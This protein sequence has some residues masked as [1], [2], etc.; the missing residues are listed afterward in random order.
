MH[1]PMI[2]IF[3]MYLLGILGGWYLC[4][5]IPFFGLI[6]LFTYYLYKKYRWNGILIFPIITLLGYINIGESTKPKDIALDLLINNNTNHSVE[7]IGNVYDIDY[8]NDQISCVI[9]SK[10][11]IYLNEVFTIPLKLK[12]YFKNPVSIKW[13]DLLHI[14]GNIEKFNYPR[15]PGGFNEKLYMKTRGIEYK[16]FSELIDKKS[17]TKNIKYGIYLLKFKFNKIYDSILPLKQSALLKAMLLGEK[18]TLDEEQKTM[19]QKAG[20][21]HILAI[22]GLHISILSLFLWKIFNYI[23]IPDK[24]STIFILIFL[25]SYYIFTGLN[26]STLRAVL[27]VSIALIGNLIRRNY[28]VYTSVTMAAFLILIKQPLYLWDAGFQLSFVAVLGLILI[29]PCFEKIYWIPKILRKILAPIMGAGLATLPIVSYHFYYISIVGFIL[30]LFIVPLASLVV[31]FGF[32]GGVLGFFWETGA[33]FTIGIVHYILIFYEFISKLFIQIPYSNIIIGRPNILFIISYYITSLG[34]VFYIFYK[35]RH[36]LNKKIKYVFLFLC[37]LLLGSAL[38][39]PNDFE[40]VFLDVGQGDSI[41]IHTNKNKTLLID[42]GEKDSKKVLLPYF[43]YKGISQIDAIFL[44]HPDRDHLIGLLGLLDTM[45]IKNI[46]VSVK[47]NGKDEIYHEF[48]LKLKKLQIPC[49]LLKQGDK[50]SIDDISIYC[51]YP[52]F[53]NNKI[54]EKESWNEISMVLQIIYKN[55][56]FLL[57]GDIEKEQENSIINTYQ[58]I[59]C[60][61]LKVPHHGSNT[62]S[63][64]KFL[65]WSNPK[66][67]IISC[68]RNNR[69]GHP[70]Q[71]VLKRYKEYNIPVII[72]ANSGAIIIKS[73]GENYKIN[74]M[75]EGNKDEYKRIKRTNKEK[76]I[77]TCLLIIW[78]GIFFKKILFRRN[79]K[80]VNF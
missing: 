75:I 19:Y 31:G 76:Y 80:K 1:R 6:M 18:S 38:F 37:T 67:A 24:I 29:D 2:W 55:N 39:K 23:R 32:I 36:K 27:M 13:G 15:N 68:G 79:T 3:L 9:E 5:T 34:I 57:T 73:N 28:D 58:P 78:G 51:L 65:D 40:M 46:F 72:T 33:Y 10:K 53:D 30:N 35:K 7:V 41:V 16:I 50:I 8:S 17:E 52:K 64:E 63:T 20:I 48:I 49:Y 60:D 59:T 45:D 43:R 11:I 61:F 14:K 74:T 54:Y 26:I 12:V 71:E 70:H 21:S 66:N 62:S 42:G 47:D 25:W 22:S 56:S 4:S 77:F 44:T 69:Y